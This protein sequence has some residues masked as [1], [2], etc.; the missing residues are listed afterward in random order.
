LGR[1]EDKYWSNNGKVLGKFYIKNIFA[2]LA[3]QLM[4]YDD[5]CD[6]NDN[7]AM[8]MESDRQ[9]AGWLVDGTW[10]DRGRENRMWGLHVFFYQ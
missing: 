8:V 5:L 3:A 6:K 1:Y 9:R 4:V 7:G 2:N 10:D